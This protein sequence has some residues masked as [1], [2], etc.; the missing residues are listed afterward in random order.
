MILLKL[1]R[2]SR[3]GGALE[4]IWWRSGFGTVATP[5]RESERH[6]YPFGDLLATKSGICYFIGVPSRGRI[7]TVAQA[8]VASRSEASSDTSAK[9]NCLAR[10]LADA[11]I[12]VDLL[13]T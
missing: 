9:Y 1:E 10:D 3:L 2:I 8:G 12:T 5:C 11:R 7:D 6:N 4:K 13:N